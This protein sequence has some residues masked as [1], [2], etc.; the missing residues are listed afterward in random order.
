MITVT[1]VS[2]RA[3]PRPDRAPA[4]GVRHHDG[5]GD[6]ACGRGAQHSRTKAA[7]DGAGR[8]ERGHLVVGDAAFRAD[9]QHDLA[10]GRNRE[11]PQAAA[12]AASCST[13]ATPPACTTDS[14]RATTAGGRFEQRDVDQPR[15]SR[16]L[17]GFTGHRSPTG[18]GLLRARR[19]PAHDRPRRLPRHD[20]VDADLGHRLDGPL[21]TVALA[22]ACT[23]VI[24]GEV[25]ARAPVRARGHARPGRQRRSP[26]RHTATPRRPIDRV[27]HPRP[28]GGPSRRADLRRRRV[29]RRRR[30]QRRRAGRRPRRTAAR[31]REVSGR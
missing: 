1:P 21:V 7:D 23:T 27:A 2:S 28:A 10:V 19:I 16:L 6:S 31:S 14:I 26:P 9:D 11:R 5:R 24:R 13:T 8:L 25:A 29:Q 20:D 15:S 30:L 18:D 17:R 4:A 12:S 22:N 3:S